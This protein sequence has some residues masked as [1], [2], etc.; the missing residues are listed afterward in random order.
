MLHEDFAPDLTPGVVERVIAGGYFD[1]QL[2]DSVRVCHLGPVLQRRSVAVHEGD[3]VMVITEKDGA[4][5]GE[6]TQ[7]R[8]ALEP[9]APKPR[10]TASLINARVAILKP[11]DQRLDRSI[12]PDWPTAVECQ[13]RN[14]DEA[15]CTAGPARV[16]RVLGKTGNGSR[17]LELS[18]HTQP[19]VAFFAA[20]SN[21]LIAPPE[22]LDE[23]PSANEKL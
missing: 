2:P 19:R 23:A 8:P 3:R 1:V 9:A 21:V 15:Y 14:G 13:P 5:L 6:I 11:Q 22:T 17:L 20:A 18:V 10:P 12:R 4:F 7:V 16:V